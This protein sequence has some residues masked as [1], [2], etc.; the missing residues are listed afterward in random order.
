[1]LLINYK[2]NFTLIWSRNY[3]ISKTDTA[4]IFPIADTRLY[5]PVVSL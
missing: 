1:M 4:T 3:I 2:T 5:V